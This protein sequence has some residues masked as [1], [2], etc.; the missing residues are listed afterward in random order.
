MTV[1]QS[2]P[3]LAR[4]DA[5]ILILGSMPGVA[6]LRAGQYYAHPQNQFWKILG[7]LLGFDPAAP[8]CT[9]TAALLDARI[10]LWDVLASCQRPGS[11]DARIH[12]ASAIANDLAGFLAEHPDIKR[13]CFNGSTAENLFRRLGQTQLPHFAIPTLR[14]P[15]TSSANAAITPARKLAAWAEA[16]G[17]PDQV[18]DWT[19]CRS[20]VSSSATTSV[21]P[22]ES[23]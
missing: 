6:S 20:A 4:A 13:I 9:R 1:V 14:L 3:P 18:R 17:S 21:Q 7:Q 2:F 11:L 10:A 15:S 16:L 22:P 8:Y 12:V 19:H 23:G 5:R